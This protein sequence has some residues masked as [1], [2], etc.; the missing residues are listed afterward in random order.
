MKD[1]MSKRDLRFIIAV[2]SLAILMAL[3]RICALLYEAGWD[4]HARYVDSLPTPEPVVEVLTVYVE[5]TPEP[6]PEPTPVPEPQRNERYAN[7]VMTQQEEDELAALIWLEARS[8]PTEGQQAVAEVVFNRILS[9]GFH[10]NTV[11]DTIYDTKYGVQFS[12]YKLV[13][14]T[15]GTEAQYEAIH[16]ALYGQNILPVEVTYF[17]R[18]PYN[19]RVWGSICCHWFC[20][21]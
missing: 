21:E 1:S 16:N 13:A 3:Y 15:Q 18:S 19:D 17:A 9:D 12:P 5:V 20:Y 8:E 7:I 14:S 11:H 6:V 4:A 10:T 2:G